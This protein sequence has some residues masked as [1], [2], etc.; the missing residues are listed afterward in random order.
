MRVAD[1]QVVGENSNDGENTYSQTKS[2][3]SANCGKC[4]KSVSPYAKVGDTCPHCGVRWGK[5]N[6]TTTNINTNKETDGAINPFAI[7]PSSTVS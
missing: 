7:S 3:V 5:E 2:S 1:A 4:G 6:S